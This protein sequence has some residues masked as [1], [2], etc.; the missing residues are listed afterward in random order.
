MQTY[1]LL[2]V[3]IAIITTVA[4]LAY[5]HQLNDTQ[6]YDINGTALWVLYSMQLC[7]LIIFYLALKPIDAFIFLGLRKSIDNEEP[8]LEKGIYCQLRH[9]MYTGIIL[10]M[11]AMPSQSSNSIALYTFITAYFIIGSKFEERRMI[12]HH[13]EYKEYMHRVPA[14]IPNIK[15]RN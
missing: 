9:P 13:Q 1:R 6:V 5:I 15:Q 4:W 12:S 10:I 14:F 7:G 11:A 3:I 2:Y 8:F